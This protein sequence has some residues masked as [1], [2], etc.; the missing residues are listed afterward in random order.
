MFEDATLQFIVKNVVEEKVRPKIPE[1]L[2]PQLA[3][4]IKSCWA[5]N[6]QNRP[7][8]TQILESLSKLTSGF[9]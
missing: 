1:T 3:E 6:P 9:V 7:D 2:S 4:L 5:T 8:Y